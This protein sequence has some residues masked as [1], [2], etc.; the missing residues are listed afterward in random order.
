MSTDDFAYLDALSLAELVR[1][2][3]V[4]PVELVDATIERIERLSE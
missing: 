1:S 3:K 4:K 2:K